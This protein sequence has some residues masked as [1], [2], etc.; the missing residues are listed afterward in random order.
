MLDRSTL[1][2][3]SE[4]S[5]S[6]DIE[7][8]VATLAGSLNVLNAQLVEIVQRALATDEWVGHGIHSPAQWLAHR[9]GLSPHHAQE[10][11]RVAERRSSFPTIIE[12]FD[13]GEL[14]LD[15]VATVVTRA[16]AWAD[17]RIAHYAKNA[18]VQQLRRTMRDQYFEGDPDEPD[19]EPSNDDRDR[20]ST[21]ITDSH[22]WRINGELDLARGSTVEAGLNEARDALFGRGQADV[23]MADAMVEMAQR[24]LDAVAS[25]SRRE[26]FKTWVHLEADT[27]NATL[28][29]GWRIPMAIRDQVLCDGSVQPVWERD[30]VPFSVGRSQRIV[31]DRTRRIIEHRDR[32]CR[33]PGCTADRF[34][35]IHHIIHWL[36]HGPTDTWNLVCLCPRHHRMHHQG[37]LG[38]AGNADDE[39]GLTFTDWKARV[40]GP[41]GQPILPTGPPPKPA[42]PYRHPSGER[43]DTNWVGLGWVHDNALKRRRNQ[44]RQA[45][46][47]DFPD[48]PPPVASDQ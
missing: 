21:G 1:D 33:V 15:Q 36:D 22:R 7:G 45:P 35:E 30:G 17:D 11:V 39:H 47:P 20:L 44:A 43:L 2:S 42:A 41:N 18:T 5:D 3:P 4:R 48:G 10:I 9:V 6:I 32:G 14:A 26:R 40:I 28:T 38:I 25:Q 13:R 46:H 12:A 23:T 16:P 27:G 19:P 37:R 8:E 34:V 24:S 29:A 31:P